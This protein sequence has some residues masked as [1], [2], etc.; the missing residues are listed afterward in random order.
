M[1]KLSFLVIGLAL[2]L[3]FSACPDSPKTPKDA[4][5]RFPEEA[6]NL[7]GINSQYDDY[8]AAFPGI[9][10]PGHLVFSSN[11]NSQGDQFDIINQY[12]LISWNMDSEKLDFTFHESDLDSLFILMNTGEDEFGPYMLNVNYKSGSNN[13]NYYNLLA[14]SGKDTSDCFQSKLVYQRFD[15]E[16]SQQ[17]YMGPYNLNIINDKCNV[18]YVSLKSIGPR[19]KDFFYPPASIEY[20]KI[21]FQADENGIADIFYADL[22]EHENIV[23]LLISDTVLSSKK[24]DVLSGAHDDKCPYVN[25]NMM[26]FTSNR[27]GGLGG[28]DLYY[29]FFENETWT[30]PVNFGSQINSSY[31]EFRPIAIYAG[32]FETDLLIFSS[33]RPGGHG[34]FDLYYVGLPFKFYNQ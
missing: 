7:T 24:V 34:G 17:I 3:L 15:E 27:L 32:G 20:S 10:L 12:M 14:Y 22:P 5:G 11:R 13:T 4:P 26:V 16:V 28:Y 33:N 2:L 6:T 8:N 18:Q 19:P 31:D 29:S 21:Y 1:K 23:E 25:G 9:Q 30:E